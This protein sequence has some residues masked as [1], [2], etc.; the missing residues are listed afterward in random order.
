[1][2]QF[3]DPETKGLSATSPVDPPSTRRRIGWGSTDRKEKA[4]PNR[5]RRH[6]VGK[7]GEVACERLVTTITRR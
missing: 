1:L 2:T 4:R 5:P 6:Y 3:G 7:F